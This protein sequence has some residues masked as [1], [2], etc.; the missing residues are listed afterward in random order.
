MN[1][2]LVVEVL[3]RFRFAA[4]VPTLKTDADVLG[5]GWIGEPLYELVMSIRADER[6]R[7]ASDW[8]VRPMP[9]SVVQPRARENLLVFLR[10]VLP[11]TAKW[12]T[13]IRAA[14]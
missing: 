7:A 5:L 14:A 9:V 2:D 13:K 1:A 6:E 12:C 8:N 10:R 11:A 3:E 4:D